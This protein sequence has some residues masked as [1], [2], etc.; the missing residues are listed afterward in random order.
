MRPLQDKQNH[1]NASSRSI[2]QLDLMMLCK[3]R[4]HLARTRLMRVRV[5]YRDLLEQM[6]QGSLRT[7]PRFLIQQT[8]YLPLF[9]EVF[10]STLYCQDNIV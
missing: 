8:W 5:E 6:V 4:Y 9:D 2:R 10:E 1:P 7:V 3:V